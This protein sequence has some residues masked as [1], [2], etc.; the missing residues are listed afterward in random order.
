M[1]T[2]KNQYIKRS[3]VWMGVIVFTTLAIAGSCMSTDSIANPESFIQEGIA[4]DEPK[5]EV[6][7]ETKTEPIPYETI[8]KQASSL[9]YGKTKVQTEGANGVKTYTYD[10]TYE[11]EKE[12]KRELV[13]TEITKEQVDEIILEG[14]KIIWHCVDVTSYDYNWNNDML[15]TSS[16]GEQRYTSYSGASVLESQ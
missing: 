10:V 5:V 11:D 9:E 16:T 2:I 12:V 6:K 7:K 13:K 4:K 15:C 1:S 8:N 14:T 3:L